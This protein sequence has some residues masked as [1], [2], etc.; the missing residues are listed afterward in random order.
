MLFKVLWLY[1]STFLPSYFIIIVDIWKMFD[2]LQ[3]I[4]RHL[5]LLPP[6]ALLDSESGG[7]D[8]RSYFVD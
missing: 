2:I 8:T 4:M 6:L 7:R 1:L 3:N 5:K